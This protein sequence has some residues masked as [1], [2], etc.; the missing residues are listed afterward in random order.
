MTNDGGLILMNTPDG[1]SPCDRYFLEGAAIIQSRLKAKGGAHHFCFVDMRVEGLPAICPVNLL[2]QTAR[3]NTVLICHD[4]LA[5]LALFYIKNYKNVVA[6]YSMRTSPEELIQSLLQLR[7]GEQILRL[8]TDRFEALTHTE[9][10]VLG[11]YGLKQAGQLPSCG[12]ASQKV[13]YQ[14][15][16]RIAGKFGRKRFTHIFH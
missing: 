1:Y 9:A 5:P 15:E 10:N 13:V 16:R 12:E 4:A 8:R 2:E 14:H 6:V 7:P 11:R 3:R